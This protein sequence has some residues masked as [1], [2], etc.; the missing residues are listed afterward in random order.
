MCDS[1]DAYI[2]NRRAF[3]PK[4]PKRAA[5]YARVSTDSQTTENQVRELREVA[6]RRGWQ[7]VEVYCDNGIS[8]A[9]KA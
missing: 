5:I 3:M 2:G 7:V 9:K 8:G 6:G 1:E 4:S